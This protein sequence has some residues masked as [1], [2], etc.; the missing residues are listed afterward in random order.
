MVVLVLLCYPE[1]LAK[2]E[3]A[4]IAGRADWYQLPASSPVS[5]IPKKREI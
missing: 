3:E 5:T 4:G 2:A 1:C